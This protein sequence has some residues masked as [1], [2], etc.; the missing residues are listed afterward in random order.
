MK[1]PWTSKI[2]ENYV[3]Q[4]FVRIQTVQT[5]NARFL[6]ITYYVAEEEDSKHKVVHI[7]R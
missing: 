2:R 4:K 3:P 6:E 5:N 1:I 7:G